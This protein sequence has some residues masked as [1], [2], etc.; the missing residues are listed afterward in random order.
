MLR[1]RIQREIRHDLCA[2]EASGPVVVIPLEVRPTLPAPKE[3]GGDGHR[4]YGGV[5]RHLSL[6]IHTADTAGPMKHILNIARSS[7]LCPLPAPTPLL[8]PTSTPA[9]SYLWP[10]PREP[11][12][13]PCHL[14]P[15]RSLLAFPSREELS[16]RNTM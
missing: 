12:T 9:S 15:V 10:C 6:M 11:S 8:P 13:L 16:N 1:L 3:D 5:Q 14:K 2:G 4:G 7:C